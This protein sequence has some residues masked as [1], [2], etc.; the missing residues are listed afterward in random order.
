MSLI[1]VY[2]ACVLYTSTLRDLLIRI[3]QA[4]LV[5]ARWTDQILDEVS[6]NIGKNRPDLA[7]DRPIRT[8]NLMNA[9]I[10]DVLVMDYE[11]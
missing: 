5:Q 10:P 7:P 8:R 3:A 11:P 2:D 1:V 9:A 4:R 6:D